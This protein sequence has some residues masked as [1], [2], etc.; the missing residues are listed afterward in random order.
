MAEKERNE[1]LPPPPVLQALV[2][3][4]TFVHAASFLHMFGRADQLRAC[5]ALA[6]LLRVTTG[7]EAKEGES[8]TGTVFGRFVGSPEPGEYPHA[9]NPGGVVYA[10]DEET[11]RALWD[12]AMGFVGGE[13]RAE[14]WFVD[15]EGRRIGKGETMR[16]GTWKGAKF[17]VMHFE[18]MRMG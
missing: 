17:R 2:G 4:A 13:W 14:A 16:G 5:G 9:T 11:F 12:E 1:Q 8:G 7:V 10:H 3:T 18:A 6:R 15:E